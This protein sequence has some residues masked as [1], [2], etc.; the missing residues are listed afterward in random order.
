VDALVGGVSDSTCAMMGTQMGA[1]FDLYAGTGCDFSAA[2][3]GASSCSDI[4]TAMADVCACAA[5]GGR[6]RQL[7]ESVTLR[8]S[9]LPSSGTLYIEDVETYRQ[10]FE[11]GISTLSTSVGSALTGVTVDAVDVQEPTPVRSSIPGWL[12]GYDFDWEICFTP[13]TPTC[14]TEGY[15]LGLVLIFLLVIIGLCC[16]CC[17][18][19]SDGQV[20]VTKGGGGVV[21][22]GLAAAASGISLNISGLPGN[23]A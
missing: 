10:E 19:C 23:V 16:L 15:I 22:I 6:R 14:S 9:V 1:Y 11:T 21:D 7:Q 18:C 5:S 17:F 20:A 12:D 4:S 13:D 8:V 2:F 3:A